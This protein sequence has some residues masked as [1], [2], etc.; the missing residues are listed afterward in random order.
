MSSPAIPRS[1]Q[2][3][4]RF[5]LVCSE[6]REFFSQEADEVVSQSYPRFLVE[7]FI[8]SE[9][10]SRLRSYFPEFQF[11]IVEDATDKMVAQGSCLPLPW[12]HPLDELPNTGCD[13][14]LT[15][16]LDARSKNIAPTIL[17]ASSIAVLP[18]YRR[19]GLSH[20]LLDY[21]QELARYSHYSA[22]ILA[23]CPSHKHLYPLTPMDR[24]INWQDKSGFAFD[25]W[26]RTN[27]QRGA[28][29]IGICGRSTVV[30]ESI[31][32]W[33]ELTRMRFPETGS[34]IIPGAT[35]PLDVNYENDRATYIEPN[36]WLSYAVS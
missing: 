2:S 24:Y 17:S 3:N 26:L 23:A 10:W 35:A 13:W 12:N 1:I 16:G 11:G 36:V 18:E 32:K 29:L 14:A 5:S 33:E 31:G 21:M 25:P 9:P 7:D 22:L 15:T 19:Q 6:E 28:E 8:R 27:L 34:Y 30:V 20:C 4:S